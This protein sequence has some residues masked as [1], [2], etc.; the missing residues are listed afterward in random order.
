MR[1]KIILEMHN[2]KTY[3]MITDKPPI[4]DNNGILTVFKGNNEVWHIR[5]WIAVVDVKE[6]G[7]R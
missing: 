6:K 5:E 1:Y 4:M 3:A 7:D 2:R